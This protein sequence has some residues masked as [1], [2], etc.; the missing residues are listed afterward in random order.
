VGSAF[1][2]QK[3]RGTNAAPTVITTG[4]DLLTISGYGYVG[5]TNTYLPAAQIL[6]DSLGTIADATSGIGGQIKFSTK[7][8]GT[9]TALQLGLTLQ[10]G[11]NPIAIFAP[12]LFA[13]LGTPANGTFTFCSDCDPGTL[14]NSTCTSAGTQ[15]GSFARRVNGVWLCD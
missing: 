9:D 10:G 12:I 5:A 3:S 1:R 8:A 7:L 11:S 4:D 13:N 2:G 14:F 6:F 15:T